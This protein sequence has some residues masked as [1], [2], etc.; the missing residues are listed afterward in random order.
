MRKKAK[1]NKRKSYQLR[2][3]RVGSEIE[4]KDDTR[5]NPV[6][7][8][9]LPETITKEFRLD[10]LSE[11][12]LAIYAQNAWLVSL[13]EKGVPVR[14]ALKQLNIERSERSV[15]DLKARYRK[16]GY[17]GLIDKRWVRTNEET[18]LTAQ[19]KRLVLA[20]YFTFTIA[21]SR[22]IWK[23]LCE[24]CRNRQLPEISESTV[25]RFIASLPE[26]YEMFR[27]GIP[28]IRLW[29]Q[30]ACPVVRYENTVFGNERWQVDDSPLPIWVR[31]R[32]KGEW[33]AATAHIT[34]ALDAHSRSIPGYVLSVK[35]PDSW[36]V[37]LM[38]R[39]AIL[40][41]KNSKW[42]NRGIPSIWQS[43]RGSNY[44]SN[45]II[46]TLKR[47][48]AI[49]DPDPP[50]YPNRKGKVER[51]F[52]TL[53]SGCLSLLPGNKGAVGLSEEAAQ[54]RVHEFLTI[55]Q[56]DAEIERWIVEEYH[57]RTHSTTGR[58]PAELWEETARLRMPASEDDL[59]LLLLKDDVERTVKNTG[60]S[61]NRDGVKR[62]YWSEDLIFN[63]RRRVR[64]AYNPE[65]MESVLVYCAA[66]G[67]MLCEAFEWNGGKGHYSIDD[68]RT[69]RSQFRRGM[70][71]RIKDYHREIEVEDRRAVSNQEWRDASEAAE[72]EMPLEEDFSENPLED[73]EVVRLMQE[74][75]S[76]D[77]GEI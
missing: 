56:L 73:A 10:E 63:F 51:F 25:K 34:L 58:K 31:V 15:R 64:I 49:M 39:R 5:L 33:V 75:R 76:R 54:K 21:G 14:Q 27:K 9:I 1:N 38:I 50:R 24:E 65:D 47:L 52:L 43:D 30:T 13:I 55:Q 42:K 32:Y 12:Q 70:V 17:Q 2:N 16:Y 74:L 23:K 67:E 40:P 19:I 41:K 60:I 61:F 6:D 3:F 68:I 29:E 66:T 22:S 46:A 59:N 20:I 72:Q 77:R 69:A 18:S 62:H 11:A 4:R 35:D 45:A 8:S 71:E 57:R 36:T 28:G 26:A 7:A 53:A 44:L 48:R 37:S